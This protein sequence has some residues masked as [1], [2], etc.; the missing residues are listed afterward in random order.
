M[1][2]ITLNFQRPCIDT[3]KNVNVLNLKIKLC[4]NNKVKRDIQQPDKNL[5]KA[6]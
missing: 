4:A 6:G 1:R 2:K 3:F 5:R